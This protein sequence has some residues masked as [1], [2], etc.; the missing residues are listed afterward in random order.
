MAHI[1]DHL[2]ARRIKDRMEGNCQFDHPQRRPQMAA[3][4]GY[5][6][7]HLVAEFFCQVGQVRDTK[8]AQIGGAGKWIKQ[9]GS[10]RVMHVPSE[11]VVLAASQGRILC[12]AASCRQQE[13]NRDNAG[14]CTVPKI[15]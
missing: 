15:G 1:P 7:D 2:V 12:D 8:R 9:S 4:H 6:L 13:G 11:H 10:R 3:G 14:K 5:G